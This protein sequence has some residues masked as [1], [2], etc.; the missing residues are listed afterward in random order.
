MTV[1]DV[2]ICRLAVEQYLAVA[3]ARR[4]RVREFLP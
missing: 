4:R 1:P 2:P 3:E